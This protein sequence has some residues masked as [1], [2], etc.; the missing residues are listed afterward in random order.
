MKKVIIVGSPGSGKSIFAAKLHDTTG[1]PLVHLDFYY[2][3]LKYNYYND[4]AAWVA[5]V[6]QLMQP[7]EWI[8][9]GNYKST[10][11]MRCQA[12]DTIILFDMPRWLCLYR[13]LTRRFRY[14][15]KQR[16]DMPEEWTEKLTYEFM[17]YVWAFSE[18]QLP[19]VLEGIAGNT[20]KK[21]IIFHK[22][23]EVDS[24]LATLEMM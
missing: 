4:R 1:M 3:Q 11:A 6:Q 10:I 14:R 8:M 7:G 16:P 17:R 23:S 12:A 2:H 18:E 22:Q 24:Y 19:I 20:N 21:I 13:I 9:D 5:R 15:N